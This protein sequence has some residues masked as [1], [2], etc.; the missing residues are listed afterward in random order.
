MD[1]RRQRLLQISLVEEEKLE[2]TV[3]ER[4]RCLGHMYEHVVSTKSARQQRYMSELSPTLA[5]RCL[6]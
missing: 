4:H 5:S 2:E 3:R 1:T 6:Y